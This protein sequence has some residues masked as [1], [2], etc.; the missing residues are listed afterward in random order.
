M[1][2]VIDKDHE[3]RKFQPFTITLTFETHDQAEDFFDGALYDASQKDER[4]LELREAMWEVM[5]DAKETISG[6]I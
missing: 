5:R 2:F 3:K 1:K 4:Y 6:R